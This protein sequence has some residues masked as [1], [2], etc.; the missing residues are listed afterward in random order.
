MRYLTSIMFI[1]Y[2]VLFSFQLYH[3]INQSDETDISSLVSKESVV[4]YRILLVGY[5]GIVIIYSMIHFYA[6][7]VL[8][9]AKK[10][11]SVDKQKYKV[12]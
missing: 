7:Y 8:Q 9:A 2:A 12:R 10:G 3:L 11:I 5:T 4:R 1:I 6:C